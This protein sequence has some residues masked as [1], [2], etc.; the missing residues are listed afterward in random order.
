MLSYVLL[1]IYIA[2]L[3]LLLCEWNSSGERDAF[4]LCLVSVILVLFSAARSETVGIDYGVYQDYFEQVRSGGWAFLTGPENP[5]RVEFGFSLL[6]YLFSLMTGNVHV[7]MT[8]V[9]VL[10]VGMT[11]IVLYRDC[12]IPWLGMFVFVS[13]NFFGNTLSFIRQS[14]AIG[15]FLFAIRFLQNRRPLPYLLLVLLASSFH[16]SMLL[17]IPVYFLAQIPVNWKS[18]S[19]YAAATVLVLIFSWPLFTFVTQFVYQGYASETGR[20]F[21]HGRSWQTALIPVLMLF[22]ALIMK[23]PL[24]A[25][26]PGNV[27]LINFSLYAGLL[28]IMT[29]KHFLFQRV[30]N[31]FFISAILL[32]PELVQAVRVEMPAPIEA[33][34]FKNSNREERME[35]LRQYRLGRSRFL[36]REA[37][38]RYALGAVLCFGLLYHIWFLLQDRI[39]LLPYLT[40]F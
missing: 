39:N 22:A 28:F 20:Y 23:K 8:A 14:L 31:I 15:V 9:A 27:V 34:N 18:V 16:K 5:Y 2:G 33:A 11:A 13:F 30:A 19:V 26:R 6:N 25:R 29:C 37:Y 12:A 3:G 21:M 36:R 17:L 4:F 35:Q 32:V 7:F 10:I 1:L 38:Y 40:F 24:L